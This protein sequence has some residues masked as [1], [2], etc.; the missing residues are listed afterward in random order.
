[1]HSAPVWLNPLASP[2]VELRPIGGAVIMRNHP[3]FCLTIA[4]HRVD[5]KRNRL[6][7]EDTEGESTYAQALGRHDLDERCGANPKGCLPSGDPHGTW[8]LIW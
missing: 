5:A 4:F 8:T 1:M 3:Q 7:R 2:L 6:S